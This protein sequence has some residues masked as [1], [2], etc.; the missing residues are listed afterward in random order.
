MVEPVRITF[1]GGLGEIGRNCAAF[2]LDGKILLQTAGA[3]LANFVANSG[4]GGTA[5][6]PILCRLVSSVMDRIGV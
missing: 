3:L 5:A 4:A 2:E 6:R 1:L